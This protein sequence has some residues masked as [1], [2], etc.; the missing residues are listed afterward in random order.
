MQ[1]KANINESWRRRRLKYN[2]SREEEG[3]WRKYRR[4]QPVS[5]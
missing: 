2:I 4:R 3:G 5:V 1:P